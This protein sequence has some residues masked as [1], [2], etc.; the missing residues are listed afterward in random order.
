MDFKEKEDNLGSE[1]DFSMLKNVMNHLGRGRKRTTDTREFLQLVSLFRY[2]H[3]NA[4]SL[5][6]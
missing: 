5:N 4:E 2:Y 1:E 6:L 3:I